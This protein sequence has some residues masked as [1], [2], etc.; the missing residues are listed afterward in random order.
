MK[1][2]DL[3]KKLSLRELD[4]QLLDLY[5]DES[6]IDYQNQR[7]I[8]ALDEYQRI[9]ADEEI[10][11]ISTSGRC[12]IGGNHTDHQHGK[13]LGCGVNLDIIAIVSKSKD[14]CIVSDNQ[15]IKVNEN[16]YDYQQE[17]KGS[18]IAL[19]KGICKRMLELNYQ[20]KGFKAYLTSDVLIGSGMSSSAAF[21]MC[22]ASIINYLYNDNK[23]DPFQLAKIS[24]YSENNY[25][26]KPCGLLDQT[27]ISQGGIVYIDFADSNNI[28]VKKL[29]VDFEKFG[30]SLC[31]VDTKGSHD[32]LTHEYS[33]IT[34]EMKQ[35]ANYFNKEFVS[36]I[37]LEEILS[38]IT[39]LRN[40]VSDRAILRSLHV[41]KEN[42]RVE[43]EVNDLL[44]S[45]IISFLNDVKESGDSSYKYLQN[46]YC[47]NACQQQSLPICLNISEIIL[48]D[49]GALRVHGGGFAGTILAFVKNSFVQEYKKRI[50]LV[51]GLNSCKV[52]KVRKYGSKVVI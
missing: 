40:K 26:G 35:V 22:I 33:A 49:N 32:D 2:T 39:E 1:V 8:K 3:K 15:E 21:E 31:V 30:Y 28:V 4:K 13:V 44:N 51:F 36:E 5:V 52:L 19:V 9:F 18:S 43:K 47:Q 14:I 48:N 23:I 41:I 16:D 27:V 34:S 46:V 11:V 24:Q 37:K 45:D 38:N 42:D 25:F 50:E 17:Q 20:V 10:N 6:V 7:Y 29:D 12:E